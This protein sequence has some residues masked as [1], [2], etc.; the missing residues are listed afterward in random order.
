MDYF[1]EHKLPKPLDK[2]E[3]F[4]LIKEANEGSQESRDKLIT[5]N[6]RLVLYEINN[7]FRNVDYDKND[8]ASVGIIGLIKAIST[9]D[10]SKEVSFSTYALRVVDNEI[11]MF[12][13]KIKKDCKV[14]SLDKVVFRGRDGGELR[15]E[16]QLC[17][18]GD[19]VEDYENQETCEIIREL[20][21]Q[22]PDRDREIIMMR[23]GFYN[24]RI[25]SQKEISDKLNISQSYVSRLITRIVKQ[26]GIQLK[27]EEEVLE[28]RKELKPEKRERTIRK[29]RRL[30]SI[31]EY[32]SDYTREQVDEMISKLSE[33]DRALLELRYGKDLDNPV[34]TRLEKKD[35][36]RFYGLLIPKMRRMLSKIDAA[37]K[38]IEIT[39]DKEV[40]H[41]QPSNETIKI[42]SI[43]GEINKD[44]CVKMLELL[45][46]PTFTQ[47]IN[48]LTVKEAIIISLKL[49]Y[50]DGKY[51]STE[52]IAQFLGIEESE[53]IET[54]KKALLLYKENINAFIDGIIEVATD[55]TKKQQI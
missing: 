49:G 28:L 26:L 24:D 39:S 44:Y 14:D 6:I 10:I 37:N 42:S 25:Y 33:K 15:L 45:R 55:Q 29:M 38:K 12:L 27:K 50:V 5:H 23:F 22:L 43:S 16:D 1:D 7:R 47:M 36:N 52:S 21:K 19:L 3:T 32:F 8:L 34:Q 31:Y 20:V 2:D 41:N 11:L 40:E 17:A 4:K 18:E 46:T 13:R 53:V 54:T 35:K 48:V 9:F 51:F 30:Q